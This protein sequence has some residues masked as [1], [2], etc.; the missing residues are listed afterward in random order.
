MKTAVII[1]GHVRSF[2][3]VFD[4]QYWHVLRKLPDPHFFCSVVD[5]QYANDLDRLGERYDSSRIFVEKIPA[6]PDCIA[7][8]GL[9]S[10][11]LDAATKFAPYALAPHANPQTILR[12]LWHQTRAFKFARNAIF[13]LGNEDDFGLWVRHRPDLFFHRFDLPDVAPADVCIPYWGGYGGINDRFAVMGHEAAVWYFN[14]YL[15]VPSLLKTGAPMHPETLSGAALDAAPV[16]VRQTMIAEFTG[17]RPP[18]AAGQ[19]EPV[20]MV[21]TEQDH[22]RHRAALAQGL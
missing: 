9:D 19:L 3:W 11:K 17:I 4:S 18:N 22:F 14:T 5:D 13:E 16:K 2:R 12:A 8:L 10:A 6:Q 15:H 7:E 20:P 1:A 21:I